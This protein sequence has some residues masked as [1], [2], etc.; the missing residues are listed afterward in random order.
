MRPECPVQD[1]V[2]TTTTLGHR[3]RWLHGHSPPAPAVVTNTY[4]R[5]I[6]TPIDNLRPARDT[7]EQYHWPAHFSGDKQYVNTYFK[8]EEDNARWTI[9][10]LMKIGGAA[11]ITRRPV[12]SIGT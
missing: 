5:P 9:A 11:L 2:S 10:L 3:A 7:C 6:P 4:E 8:S 1:Q 12:A